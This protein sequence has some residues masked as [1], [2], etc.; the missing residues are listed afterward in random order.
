MIQTERVEDSGLRKKVFGK[1]VE[2]SVATDGDRPK[3]TPQFRLWSKTLREMIYDYIGGETDEEFP[4][5]YNPSDHEEAARWIF[6]DQLNDLSFDEI[7]KTIFENIDPVLVKIRL[8][9]IFKRRMEK[10]EKKG[11]I[12]AAKIKDTCRRRGSAL[13][14]YDPARRRVKRTSGQSWIDNVLCGPDTEG[15]DSECSE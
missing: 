8:K 12:H 6:G 11:K 13:G 1:W 5:R 9:L 4:E 2:I 10:F 7:W 3:R 15:G 14:N